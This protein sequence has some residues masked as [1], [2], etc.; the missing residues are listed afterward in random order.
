MNDFLVSLQHSELGLYDSD[1]GKTIYAYK[2]VDLTHLTP[3]SDQVIIKYAKA[4]QGLIAQIVDL[5][6]KEEDMGI[7]VHYFLNE[8][9]AKKLSEDEVFYSR[10]KVMGA[11]PYEF[12]VEIFTNK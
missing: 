1:T 6:K 9:S 2:A 5:Y 7:T 11:N 3:S 8:T 4:K 10:C 12:A